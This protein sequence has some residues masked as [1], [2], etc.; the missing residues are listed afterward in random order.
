MVKS[1]LSKHKKLLEC[2]GRE[3][4]LRIQKEKEELEELKK[5]QKNTIKK[6]FEEVAS[7]T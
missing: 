5:R 3:E 7:K 4:R 2:L 1:H 6:T